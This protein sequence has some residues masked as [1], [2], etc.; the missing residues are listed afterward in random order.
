MYFPSLT[1]HSPKPPVHG[2]SVTGIQPLF[3]SL[4]ASEKSLYV[5]E[6]PSSDKQLSNFHFHGNEGIFDPKDWSD[7]QHLLPHKENVKG[8][9]IPVI[10]SAFTTP[11]KLAIALGMPTT[12]SMT[13]MARE[14]MQLTTKKLIPPKTVSTG[15]EKSDPPACP[16][17]CPAVPDAHP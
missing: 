10:T 8:Y 1:T 17:P 15:P 14:W 2:V 16:L 9:D 13:D 4:E 11:Q 7:D 3:P 12:L 5:S 6:E